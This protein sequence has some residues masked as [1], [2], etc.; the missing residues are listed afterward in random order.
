MSPTQTAVDVHSTP[1]RALEGNFGRHVEIATE[2][3]PAMDRES[4]EE[5]HQRV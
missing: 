3:Y 1:D 2:R 5:A 4:I